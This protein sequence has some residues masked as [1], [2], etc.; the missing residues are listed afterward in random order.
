MSISSPLLF[1]LPKQALTFFWQTHPA[2]ILVIVLLRSTSDSSQYSTK[3]SGT[4]PISTA[5]GP[6]TVNHSP[7]FGPTEILLGT[8]TMAILS[9]AGTSQFS[10]EQ[11]TNVPQTAVLLRTA[12]FSIFSPTTRHKLVR[13]QSPF[14]K[15]HLAFFPFYPAVIPYKKALQGL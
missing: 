13:F 6:S 11:S 4:P 7:S 1:I 3:S 9:T 14:T 8:D 10:N 12:E 5:S 2:L 15:R